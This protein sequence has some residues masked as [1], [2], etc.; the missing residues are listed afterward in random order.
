MAYMLASAAV[1]LLKLPAVCNAGMTHAACW[2]LN[3]HAAAVNVLLLA[4]LTDAAVLLLRK[5]ISAQA[6][7]MPMLLLLLR[8]AIYQSLTIIAVQRRTLAGHA[9]LLLLL[10]QTPTA[11]L[12]L[13]PTLTESGSPETVHQLHTLSSLGSAAA[14][15]ATATPFCDT[16]CTAHQGWRCNGQHEQ[17]VSSQQAPPL[18]W[19][20][21]GPSKEER[22]DHYHVGHVVSRGQHARGVQ[23]LQQATH[24]T[25]GDNEVL[26]KCCTCTWQA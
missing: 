17:A 2:L 18:V 20:H 10:L 21:R 19:P 24:A 16:R 14:A 25:P 1:Q 9:L 7:G 3:G 22:K 12:K 11:P 23:V 26:S 5:R 4:L 13:H 8:P 6:S 15:A